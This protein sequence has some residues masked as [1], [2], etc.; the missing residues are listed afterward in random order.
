MSDLAVIVASI[1]EAASADL[2]YNLTIHGS[3]DEP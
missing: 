1:T 3:Q 2:A